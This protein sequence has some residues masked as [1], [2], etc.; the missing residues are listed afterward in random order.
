[1]LCRYCKKETSSLL[2]C[3]K[4]FYPLPYAIDSSNKKDFLK[5]LLLWFALIFI[6]PIGFF[7]LWKD[8]Y[9]DFIGR[10]IATFAVVFIFAFA[11]FVK[12]QVNQGK[13]PTEQN[14][15]ATNAAQIVSNTKIPEAQ[16]N[17]S[18]NLKAELFGNK[19]VL[20]LNS[21]II[22]GCKLNVSVIYDSS[23]TDNVTV[24]SGKFTKEYTLGKLNPGTIYVRVSL[25]FDQIK[26]EQPQNV[27]NVYGINGEKIKATNI[28]SY[29]YGG[30][31]LLFE[32]EIAYP[33]SEAALKEKEK[34]FNS[35]IDD[36]IQRNKG[37][38]IHITPLS[39]K[40]GWS[41][42]KVVINDDWYSLQQHEKERLISSVS[43]E[44]E[45]VVRDI[46]KKSD[47]VSIHYY[48]QYGKELASPK[49]LG[50]GYKIKK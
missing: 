7:L 17:I 16:T 1:M 33:N 46:Y 35:D 47:I 41:F 21:N 32:T 8:K 3:Q 22:D 34:S 6:P 15:I 18:G 24:Y 19:L 38:L 12:Y 28:K 36:I 14:Q 29:P 40:T 11:F 23:I 9:Y 5:E 13:N 42:V 37:F 27:Q 2:L 50:S 43:G 4:C 25:E 31:Y 39:K 10:M 49:L 20:V 30:K 44:I 45:V 48:D 26:T